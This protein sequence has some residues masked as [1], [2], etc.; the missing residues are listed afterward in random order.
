M[1]MAMP[2]FVRSVGRSAAVA[3]VAAALIS[4][5]APPARATNIERVVTPGGI[6]VWVVRD[7]AVPLIA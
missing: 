4:S 5:A 2:A 6:E 7:A 3:L 1:N